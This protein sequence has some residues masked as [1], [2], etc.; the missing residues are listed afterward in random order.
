MGEAR[1]A[2]PQRVSAAGAR[3]G[4]CGGGGGVR[5]GAVPGA[6]V[7]SRSPP[8]SRKPTLTSFL[9]LVARP[10]SLSIRREGAPEFAS[11]A[12]AG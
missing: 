2:H 12:A 5:R 7:P 10:P 4:G 8:G 11:P 1:A 9:P 6:R 3:P